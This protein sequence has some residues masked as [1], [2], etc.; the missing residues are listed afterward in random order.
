MRCVRPSGPCWSSPTISGCSITS[1]RTGCMCSPTVAWLAPAVLSWRS[2]S[3]NPVTPNSAATRLR[4]GS[5]D[6]D[7][8]VQ[9]FRTKAEQE[10]LDLFTSA[11]KV[12]PGARN[13]WVSE[14]RSNAIEAY[15]RLGLPHRRIEAWK[16]TDLRARLPEAYP[17]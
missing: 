4:K 6:M 10:L 8:P 2:S 15:G 14:L 1:C 7:L 12:L 11:E 5:A 17:L 16:Y 9:Q 3:R 13:A